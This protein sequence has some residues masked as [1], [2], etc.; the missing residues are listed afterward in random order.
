MER[1][2]RVVRQA[3][4][5]ARG[6]FW[7]RGNSGSIRCGGDRPDPQDSLCLQPDVLCMRVVRTD[8]CVAR[9]LFEADRAAKLIAAFHKIKIPESCY[10][11]GFCYRSV[12]RVLMER[13]S[14]LRNSRSY[15]RTNMK[16]RS[17]NTW[18]SA[19]SFYD[20]DRFDRWPTRKQH[21]DRS[22]Q[23]SF[24]R[25]FLL[26]LMRYSLLPLCALRA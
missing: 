22:M 13:Q 7:R 21:L 3:G 17:P 5:R 14:R 23:G 11:Q 9:F 26:P 20:S 2:T 19:D 4:D 1:G 15:Y 16:H 8:G 6:I 10:S 18:W 25:R 12:V 24:R